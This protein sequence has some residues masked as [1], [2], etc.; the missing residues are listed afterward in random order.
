MTTKP[1]S[2]HLL[3]QRVIISSEDSSV[4]ATGVITAISDRKEGE[5]H[6]DVEISYGKIH[7]IIL[8]H[9]DVIKLSW[10]RQVDATYEIHG[11]KFLIHV[12]NS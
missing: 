1:S 3:G 7:H 9:K 2:F 10:V 5:T 6:Y 4:I 8:S 12:Y 11:K